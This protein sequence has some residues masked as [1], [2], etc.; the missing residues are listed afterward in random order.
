MA[1]QTAAV[2]RAVVNDRDA[3]SAAVTASTTSMA[4]QITSALTEVRAAFATATAVAAVEAR[5][6]RKGLTFERAAAS[7]LSEAAANAGDGGGSFT[8]GTPG[9]SGSKVGDAVVTFASDLGW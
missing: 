5:S 9:A 1:A 4:T 3:V 8:G 2:Q 6:S 7:A